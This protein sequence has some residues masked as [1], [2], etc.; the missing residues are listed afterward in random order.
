M[1]KSTCKGKRRKAEKGKNLD[2]NYECN[3]DEEFG[4]ALSTVEV[5]RGCFSPRRAKRRGRERASRAYGKPR[6]AFSAMRWAGIAGNLRVS[7]TATST[8]HGLRRPLR[9]P[10]WTIRSRRARVDRVLFALGIF[11]QLELAEDS[12]LL[13]FWILPML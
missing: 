2:S 7:A 1:A 13:I 8:G 12:Q 3:E 9:A 11:G 6:T 10:D 4:A 5:E